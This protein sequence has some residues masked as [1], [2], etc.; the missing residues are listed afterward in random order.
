MLSLTRKV[1]QSLILIL[2]DGRRIKVKIQGS[3][4]KGI[5]VG[6]HCARTILVFR[7][8]LLDAD[9][10]PPPLKEPVLAEAPVLDCRNRAREK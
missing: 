4:P 2:E 5:S 1:G 6:V 9:G 3:R 7:E 10:N 8:E